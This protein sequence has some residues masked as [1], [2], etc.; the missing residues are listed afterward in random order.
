MCASLPDSKSRDRGICSE[1]LSKAKSKNR[2]SCQIAGNVAYITYSRRRCD[3]VVAVTHCPQ[4]SAD[5]STKV[6]LTGIISFIA[7]LS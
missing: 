4:I 6:V 1:T 7:I 3:T 2:H 5:R